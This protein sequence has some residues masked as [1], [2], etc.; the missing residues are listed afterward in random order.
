MSPAAEMPYVQSRFMAWSPIALTSTGLADAYKD[1]IYKGQE[2]SVLEGIPTDGKLSWFTTAAQK[3]GEANAVGS[4]ERFDWT[5]HCK[6]L[7]FQMDFARYMIDGADLHELDGTAA[8]IVTPGAPDMDLAARILLSHYTRFAAL[9]YRHTHVIFSV[10]DTELHRVRLS[11]IGTGPRS[12]TEG[13]SVAAGQTSPGAGETTRTPAVGAFSVRCG[14]NG[15]RDLWDLTDDQGNGVWLPDEQ[16]FSITTVTDP[17]IVAH[18][19]TRIFGNRG[20]AT[21]PNL[22]EDAKYGIRLKFGILADRTRPAAY[23]VR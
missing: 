19:N 3:L 18:L 9:F 1:K 22:Y 12:V 21:L 23:G 2:D 8:G 15:L 14:D 13:L 20:D 7:A 17:N 10:A 5:V 6:A 4:G 16:K 11:K